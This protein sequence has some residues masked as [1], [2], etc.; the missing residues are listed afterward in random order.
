[1]DCQ[2]L[3][4]RT[5]L[6]LATIAAACS[7]GV[8]GAPEPVEP[9]PSP[10]QISWQQDEVWAII[11]FGP[12]SFLDSEWG[13]G[14]TD[15]SVF[16]PSRL[17][18]EQWV[19]TFKAAGI[20]GVILTAKHHDG[21][22][23]W[24]SEYTDYTVAASP[25]KDGAGDIVGELS[26]ACE[27]HGL[28]F[29]VYLSP[30]DRHEASY[31][32]KEYLVFYRNQLREL[33]TRYGKISEVFL[34]GANGGDG[35]Y[36]GAKESRT[37]N[38]R[39]YYDFPTIFSLVEELQP[40]AL[41]FSDGGPGCRWSG[42]EEGIASETNWSFL[43]KG[44]VY[45]GYPFMDELGPGHER[46]NAWIPAECDVSIRGSW[47]FR[48]GEDDTVKT[49]EQLV[50]LYYKSVGRNGKLLINFPVDREG[51]I[52]PKDSASICEAYRIVSRQLK[53]D[54][55][56]NA[57][58]SASESRGKSY[59]A[60][61][62]LDGNPDTF[63]APEDGTRRASLEF[64]FK[65]KRKVDRIV[66]QEKIDLGQRVKG[67][68]VEYYDGSSWQPVR[69]SERQT[70]IGYKRI[71]RFQPVEAA[72]LRVN[73]TNSRACPCISSVRACYAE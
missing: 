6:A 56:A 32:T 69:T 13:Y 52:P 43:K 35:W 26:Q 60:D 44:S 71:I 10:S 50:E 7:G 27:R 46:G 47:F 54:I 62:V 22:C 16:N 8:S 40:E 25:Y 72:A 37:I 23:L 51:L 18:C 17:D 24:P 70:T 42:N 48:S 38:R 45:P 63:W 21:F 73:I 2:V 41:I 65:E 57:S 15:P 19:R 39:T 4:R 11:H 49:P 28:K 36:G 58:A 31:G 67:F 12:N 33:L 1:M 14:D 5:A 34:D 68:Y 64:T 61:K 30:W 3:V 9:I 66:L 29:G 59:S 20:K 53:D 55:L